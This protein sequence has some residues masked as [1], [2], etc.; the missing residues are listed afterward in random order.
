[1]RPVFQQAAAA[2]RSIICACHLIA[3]PLG[4]P[5]YALVGIIC[6]V[7]KKVNDFQKNFKIL[8]FVWQNK[9]M[10]PFD[11]NTSLMIR[12]LMRLRINNFLQQRIEIV[13]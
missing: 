12:F 3:P 8:G 5:G 11:Q 2:F 10:T 6:Y 1:M 4:R 9:T 7:C 13:A